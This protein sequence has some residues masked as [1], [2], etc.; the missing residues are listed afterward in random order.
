MAGASCVG[1]REPANR[2]HVGCVG[3]TALETL[4][5]IGTRLFRLRKEL[6]GLVI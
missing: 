2:I 6:I 1:G 5:V 4:G 3:L